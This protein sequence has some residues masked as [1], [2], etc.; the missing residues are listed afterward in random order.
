MV[1]SIRLNVTC[2]VVNISFVRI[3]RLSLFL[4][5]SLYS[6]VVYANVSDPPALRDHHQRL[7][8]VPIGVRRHPVPLLVE[9]N[10][11]FEQHE[12]TLCWASSYTVRQIVTAAVLSRLLRL[13]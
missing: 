6:R 4:D 8:A 7:S 12:L 13:Q 10:E 3:L 2:H 11:A 5:V 1:E 9:D